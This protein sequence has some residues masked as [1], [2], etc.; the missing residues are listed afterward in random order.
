[1]RSTG[2]VAIFASTLWL[3]LGGNRVMGQSFPQ[4]APAALPDRSQLIH[5]LERIEQHGN[6]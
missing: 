2:V 6:G 4:Q 5:T 3:A 1:M